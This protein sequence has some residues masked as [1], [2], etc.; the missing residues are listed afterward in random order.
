MLEDV[1]FLWIGF[2]FCDLRVSEYSEESVDLW[3]DIKGGF[4]DRDE[5]WTRGVSGSEL[6]VGKE[7]SSP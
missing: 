5:N 7:Y 1:L 3:V 6:V 2:E 4:C